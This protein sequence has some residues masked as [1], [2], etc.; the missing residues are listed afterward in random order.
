M[1]IIYIYS[2]AAFILKRQNGVVGTETK[3]LTKSK[4]FTLSPYIKNLPTLMWM[5]N[6]PLFHLPFNFYLGPMLPYPAA[7]G[8]RLYVRC[9]VSYMLAQRVGQK[10]GYVEFKLNGMKTNRLFHEVCPR[11]EVPTC[12]FLHNVFPSSSLES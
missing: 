7:S 9:F 3:R 1:L 5:K 4:T 11:A 6:F 2:M 10:S 12:F 8:F